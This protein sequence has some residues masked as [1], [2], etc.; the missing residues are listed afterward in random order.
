MFED[1]P[2]AFQPSPRRVIDPPRPVMVH[3]PTLLPANAPRGFGQDKILMRVKAGGLDLTCT[4]PGLLHAW[5][6][7]NEGTWYGIVELIVY[8]G[9]GHGR[10]RVTQLCPASSL[11]RPGEAGGGR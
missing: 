8:T 9:N 10:L 4:V 5:V 3:L 7:G 11:A 6:L 2:D 1:W